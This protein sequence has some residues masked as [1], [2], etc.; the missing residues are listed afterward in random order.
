MPASPRARQG[1]REGRKQ[2]SGRGQREPEELLF[3]VEVYDASGAARLDEDA[4]QVAQAE[5][6]Y[7]GAVRPRGNA[8]PERGRH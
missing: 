8:V 5:P 1:A 3:L 2:A 7:L 4:I 6:Q